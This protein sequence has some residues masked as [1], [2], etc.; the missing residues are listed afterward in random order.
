M[1]Y[2]SYLVCIL[3]ASGLDVGA[4]APLLVQYHVLRPHYLQSFFD[5]VTTASFI[6]NPKRM[7]STCFSFMTEDRRNLIHP[8]NQDWPT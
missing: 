1:C 2:I 3:V 4:S 7:D 6:L 5:T 8:L